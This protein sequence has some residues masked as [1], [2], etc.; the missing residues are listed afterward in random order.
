MAQCGSSLMGPE[1]QCHTSGH[2]GVMP[3]LHHGTVHDD[4][5]VEMNSRKLVSPNAL[6]TLAIPDSHK[7]RMKNTSYNHGVK[8]SLNAQNRMRRGVMSILQ[9][10]GA[11]RR[12]SWASLLGGSRTTN[13]A[14]VN[15]DCYRDAT[16]LTRTD[17]H[18]PRDPA[19]QQQRYACTLR[20]C[21]S[22]SLC[23]QR[24]QRAECS[25]R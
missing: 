23:W 11:T 5:F 13:R 2:A 25:A 20:K 10:E 9:V 17:S 14:S 16:Q 1:T 19:P 8:H 12:C 22:S 24:L 3:Q 7:H 15:L 21:D 18:V 4:S 6:W